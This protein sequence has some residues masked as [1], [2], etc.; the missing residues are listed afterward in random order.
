[1]AEKLIAPLE[2]PALTPK[3][4]FEHVWNAFIKAFTAAL[5]TVARSSEIG[6]SYPLSL[7]LTGVA[8]SGLITV[9]EHTRQYPSGAKTVQGGSV[10]GIAYGATAY[11]YYDDS[12]RNAGL[13]SFSAST[14]FTDAFASPT[15]PNR[16]FVGKITM[17]ANAGASN[18]TGTAARP[19]GFVS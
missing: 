5:N 17:P 15:N 4:V 8:S 16:H 11:V 3:G 10:S 9:S 2:R 13:V 6:L 12:T 19:P 1:M 7:T 18:T 14:T